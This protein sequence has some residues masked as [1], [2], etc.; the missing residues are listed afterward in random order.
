MKSI[1][2]SKS[3]LFCKFNFNNIYITKIIIVLIN[4]IIYLCVRSTTIDF[5]SHILA[6]VVH[7]IN[8]RGANFSWLTVF[9]FINAS[10][11]V[12]V[13]HFIFDTFTLLDFF[14]VLGSIIVSCDSLSISFKMSF[15]SPKN[16]I[17]N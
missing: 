1:S 3:R 10:I 7:F 15:C 4:K 12:I 14:F 11:S 13:D 5:V 8:V 6:N 16:L 2:I 9:F 17:V